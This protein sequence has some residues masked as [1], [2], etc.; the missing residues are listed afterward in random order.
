MN[1]IDEDITLSIGNFRD[2]N[3]NTFEIA[4]NDDAAFRPTGFNDLSTVAPPSN[5]FFTFNNNAIQNLKQDA[6]SGNQFTVDFLPATN[7][8]GLIL[9]DVFATSIETTATVSNNLNSQSNVITLTQNINPISETPVVS[10]NDVSIVEK[11]NVDI[12]DTNTTDLSNITVSF[13]Q[14]SNLTELTEVKVVLSVANDPDFLI[15]AVLPLMALIIMF[16]QQVHC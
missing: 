14:S 1:D 2:A 15:L 10:L 5:G 12:T 13:S 9:F 6:I 8:N 3:G 11:T 7:L 4:K 16:L